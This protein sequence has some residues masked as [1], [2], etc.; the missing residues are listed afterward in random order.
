MTPIMSDDGRLLGHV[1]I[2]SAM[3]PPA[4]FVPGAVIRAA[5]RLPVDESVRLECAEFRVEQILFRHKA[6]SYD[7]CSWYLVLLD[8]VPPRLWEAAGFVKFDGWAGT[9]EPTG[10]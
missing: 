7:R 2:D 9:G 10:L 4:A 3:I 6:W 5:L 8:P 1:C